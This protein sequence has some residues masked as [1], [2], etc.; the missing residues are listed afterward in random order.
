MQSFLA[1]YFETTFGVKELAQ[2][3]VSY[4]LFVTM[5]RFIGLLGY[6]LGKMF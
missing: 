2:L 6:Q 1:S 4:K 3:H 5:V